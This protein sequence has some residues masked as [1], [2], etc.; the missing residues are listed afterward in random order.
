MLIEVK[1]DYLEFDKT[2]SGNEVER[3][4][5]CGRFVKV[6][7]NGCEIFGACSATPVVLPLL[8]IASPPQPDDITSNFEV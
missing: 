6:P 4:H 5:T 2:M 8:L 7:S 3:N 1:G